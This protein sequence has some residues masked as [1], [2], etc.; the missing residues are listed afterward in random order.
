L[1]ENFAESEE[2]GER[3]TVKR[4]RS[5]KQA[6]E[7]GDWRHEQIVMEP[8]NPE[9]EPWEIRENDQVRILAEFIQVLA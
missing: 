5:R 8:L 1:V 7:S 4:Y 6:G 3:Y 9:F 2:G